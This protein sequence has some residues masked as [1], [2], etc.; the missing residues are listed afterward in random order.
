MKTISFIIT[1]ALVSWKVEAQCIPDSLLGAFQILP[2]S[3]SLPCVEAGNYFSTVLHF[4]F[5]T[6]PALEFSAEYIFDSITGLPNGIVYEFDR[7]DKRYWDDDFRG[8]ITFSGITNDRPGRYPIY[9]YVTMNTYDLGVP[10]GTSHEE[11]IEGLNNFFHIK[12]SLAGTTTE[13]IARP[14]FD[15]INANDTCIHSKFNSTGF[16]KSKSPFIRVYPNPTNSRITF[17]FDQFMNAL[18]IQIFNSFGQMVLNSPNNSGMN[19]DLNIGN[20]SNGIYIFRIRESG[21]P[22]K[23]G[24]LVIN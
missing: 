2:K 20:L 9:I 5:G 11:L 10:S 18:D 24:K 22:L 7:S 21:K 4:N 15:L 19:V 3:D 13:P 8:C 1:F 23:T 14:F 17:R 12:D 16:V 6:N